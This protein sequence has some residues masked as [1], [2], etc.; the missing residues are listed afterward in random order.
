MQALLIHIWENIASCQPFSIF[1]P[2]QV[3]S[4]QLHSSAKGQVFSALVDFNVRS[5]SST[6][7]Q[8]RSVRQGARTSVP[9][10]WRCFCRAE[11]RG[12]VLACTFE[13]A[14]L[15]CRKKKCATCE[16]QGLS[17]CR[18]DQTL[19]SVCLPRAR[20]SVGQFCIENCYKDT[21]QL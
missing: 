4:S 9:R 12:C 7:V 11:A 6:L 8:A 20:E 14:V 17:L 10:R 5:N 3:E 1:L 15:I 21:S 13:Y 18:M 16:V 19:E 2:N